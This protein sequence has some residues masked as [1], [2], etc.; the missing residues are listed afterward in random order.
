MTSSTIPRALLACVSLA[1]LTACAREPAP[2]AQ[3]ATAARTPAVQSAATSRPAVPATQVAAAPASPALPLVVVHKSPTCGCCGLWVEHMRQAGF[4]VEV[5]E[6]DDLGLV[7]QRLGIP[8]G[9]GSCHTAEVA[10]Y[11]VEGH[12]P[13]GDV[14]RL[15]AQRPKAKGLV[16]PGMPLGSPGMEVP[17]GTVQPYTVELV[18][19][20]G[21]TTA[22]AHH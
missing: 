6:M 10:G 16:L 18:D 2:V 1:A 12:V 9:K 11:F 19:P 3:D 5:R 13:A 14:K 21:N 17:D 20:S 22:F 8:Y 15:L 4:P 7:K